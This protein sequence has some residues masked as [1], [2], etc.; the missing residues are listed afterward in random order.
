M[1]PGVIWTGANTGVT[2][3]SRDHGKSWSDVTIPGAA[4]GERFLVSSLEASHFD[5]GT[6]YASVDAHY[7]GDYAPY[8]YRT[9]DYGKT[10]RKIVT[11]LPAGLPGGAFV[12]V[13]RADPKRRGLLFAGTESAVYVSFDDGDHWQSLMLNLP[14]TSFRDIAVHDNDLITGTFG[15]GIWVLD[16]FAAL[17]QLTP[18]IATEPA[19]LFK[20]SDAVRMRRNVNYNTPFPREE[21]QAPNPPEGAIFYYS[22][23][24]KPSADIT[25]DVLDAR[26]D[27]V[28]HLTS[29]APTPVREAA[30]AP[31]EQ[32]WLAQPTALPTNIGLNRATWDLRY[33]PPP[34]FAHSFVFNGN[35][36][37]TPAT[38]EGPMA[39]PGVYR[40]RLSVD[41][42]QYTQTVTLRADPRS[43]V[44]WTALAAQHALL[45]R[46]YA[47]LAATWTDFRTVTALRSAIAKIA[48]SP[49]DTVSETGRA[50][51]TLVTT[52][53]SMAGDS[54]AD[55][56]Q[57]WDDRPKTW[58]LGALNQQFGLEL[59]TQDNADHA[60]TQPMLAVAR[61]DCEELRK[62]VVRWGEFVQRDL[63]T[64]N[65]LLARQGMTPLRA[66]PERGRL[67]VRT[68]QR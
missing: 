7:R 11:G 60:P 25:V 20:P 39:M 53:D 42:Q 30:R 31:M 63:A 34:A 45:M 10:W 66:P 29:A 61:L 43:H 49:N 38:P 62:L 47:G 18:V 28:R 32:F 33:D 9:R 4:I 59:T 51:R 57:V 15:R 65:R 3:V 68:V 1:T 8:I 52:L 16:D 19:H 6:A 54:L 22:L 21:P 2:H 50:A 36:G 67:C 46:L 26:G 17:R 24:A 44:S 37:S 55:A 27:V 64:F 56:R 48:P 5:A 41:G 13:V 40:I 35:P 12:R 23:A 14:T 58:S